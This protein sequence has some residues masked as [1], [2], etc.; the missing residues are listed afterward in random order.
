M[1][2]V[3]TRFDDSGFTVFGQVVE[4]LDIAQALTVDDKIVTITVIEK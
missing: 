1:H 4:G 3:D 2:V